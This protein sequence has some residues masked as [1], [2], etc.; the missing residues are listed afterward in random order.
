MN[1]RYIL[2]TVRQRFAVHKVLYSPKY[3]ILQSMLLSVCEMT[4]TQHSSHSPAPTSTPH[5]RTN[6]TPTTPHPHSQTYTPHTHTH[7]STC[8]PTPTQ[9]NTKKTEPADVPDARGHRGAAAG[10]A[11]TVHGAAG[12]GGG[13]GGAA[14]A[15]GGVAEAPDA[16]RDRHLR[17]LHGVRAC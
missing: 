2:F 10:A 3:I 1:F 17:P 14:L 15:A 7:V 8:I 4:R 12:G 11:A 6:V 13:G 16:I 9:T 5:I